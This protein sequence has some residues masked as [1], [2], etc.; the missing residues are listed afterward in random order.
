M[1]PNKETKYILVGTYKTHSENLGWYINEKRY[2][3]LWDKLK[4][5]YGIFDSRNNSFDNIFGNIVGINN[6]HFF[7]IKKHDTTINTKK[8]KEV[9][10]LKR[11]HFI[12]GL[13]KLFNEIKSNPSQLYKLGLQGNNAV[14]LVLNFLEKPERLNKVLLGSI[15]KDYRLKEFGEIKLNDSNLKNLRVYK[16]YNLTQPVRRKKDLATKFHKTWNEFL[17]IL[18][19]QRLCKDADVF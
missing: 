16:I 3:M 10:R 19:Q 14:G 7:D 15:A 6:F 13:H 18:P 2:A 11:E 5:K 12:E 8:D 1:C 4:E 9:F 17:D